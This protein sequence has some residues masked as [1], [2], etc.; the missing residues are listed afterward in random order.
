MEFD[1]TRQ[2]VQFVNILNIRHTVDIVSVSL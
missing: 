1:K 2:N